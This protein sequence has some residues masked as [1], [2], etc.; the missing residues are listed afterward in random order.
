MWR[1]EE[2]VSDKRWTSEQ[3]PPKGELPE[4]AA[5]GEREGKGGGARE[6]RRGG[7]Q[8]RVQQPFPKWEGET[9]RK[10]GKGQV[11]CHM[12][13]QRQSIWGERLSQE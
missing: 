9:E 2:G 3:L 5:K 13:H 4:A 12:L 7:R 8:A 1:V 11:N 6:G 10:L